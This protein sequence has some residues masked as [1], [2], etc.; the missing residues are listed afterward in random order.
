VKKINP[1][2]VIIIFLLVI[3][4]LL[5]LKTNSQSNSDQT[6]LPDPSITYCKD[7]GYR[8]DVRVNYTGNYGGGEYGVCIL[9]NGK[10][11]I[12][13]DFFNGRCEQQYTYCE[14]HGGKISV[15]N[16]GCEFTPECAICTLSNGVVCHEWQY[17]KGE[18][19]R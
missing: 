18:C 11:C 2:L 15:T 1:L 10:E 8:V 17:F 5:N 14:K 12:A 16:E 19:P 6:N 9:P 3:F 7:L 4:S 13:W